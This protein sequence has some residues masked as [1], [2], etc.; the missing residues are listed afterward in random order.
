[1][2]SLLLH[3]LIKAVPFAMA[4]FTIVLMAHG[5]HTNGDPVGPGEPNVHMIHGGDPV[6]PGEPNIHFLHGGDPVGPGEPN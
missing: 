6:G 1:M 3:R 4:A 5:V 2:N